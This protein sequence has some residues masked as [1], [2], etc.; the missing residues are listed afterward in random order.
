ME[1]LLTPLRFIR[2]HRSFIVTIDKISSFSNSTGTINNRR[3]TIGILYKN[4][5]EKSWK[6]L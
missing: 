6:Q 3:I 5:V 4:K 1:K 2:I